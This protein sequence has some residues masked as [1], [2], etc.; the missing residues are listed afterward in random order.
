MASPESYLRNSIK[1]MNIRSVIDIGTGHGGVFDYWNWERKNLSYK[2]CLD[3]RYIRPDISREWNRI[4]A[5]ATHLPLRDKSF[6][7][8]QSTEMI[9]HINPDEHER[10]I[11]ELIRI[12]RKGI[13]LTSSDETRHR[14][15]EQKQCEKFN[16]Y[17]KYLGIVSKK[18][19]ERYGF[20]IIMDDGH[21]LKAFLKLGLLPP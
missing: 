12:S 4:I 7:L 13:Y 18:T 14:G 11:R 9:D 20:N 3:I 21:R 17:N 1:G 8:A 6:D 19:L 15:P 5:S 2:A 10:V 16:P